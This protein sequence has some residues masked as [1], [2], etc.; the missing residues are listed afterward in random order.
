MIEWFWVVMFL[1]VVGACSV[2]LY[3]TTNVRD[4]EQAMLHARN[5]FITGTIVGALGALWVA[6]EAI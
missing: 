1:V 4:P 6:W 3:Y 2:G 5:V